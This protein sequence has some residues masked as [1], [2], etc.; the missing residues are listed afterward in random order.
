MTKLALLPLILLAACGDNLKPGGAADVDSGVDAAPLPPRAIVV[1]GDFV[2]GH[3]GVMSVVDMTTRTIMTNVAP[4]GAVGEDPVLRHYGNELYV[5]NR[6]SGNNVTILDAATFAFV[7]QLGTG[8]SSNP[9]DAV[10]IGD[11]VFVA[12]LGNKGGVMVERGSTVVTEIDLSADDPDGKPNCN[13]V[14]FA[15]NKL[16]FSCGLLDDTNMFLPP[17]GPGKIYV[18]NPTTLAVEQTVTMMTNNPIALFEQI[19]PS[20]PH[21]ND[22]LMPTIDFGT[23]MGC[24]ERITSAGTFGSAGCVVENSALGGFAFASRIGF[25]GTH[26]RFGVS[27]YPNGTV[28]DF[29]L[30]ANTLGA[31]SMT[32]TAQVVAD[33]AICPGGE[34][35]IAD[36]PP[37][38]STAA[39]GLRIYDGTTEKTT[40]PLAVG[41][42]PSSSHG[43]VC[44]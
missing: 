36:N 22:V 20:A 29:D 15:F 8:A 42:K 31:T 10:A 6:A 19:P 17:R 27:D 32:A 28:R 38:P 11:K 23:G 7:D 4:A 34:M 14:Y 16:L 43:L 1:A 18:V 44:F 35:V 41:L 40:E 24:V 13:S 12:T 33:L 2:P 30:A 3:P 25:E 39:N 26:A 9:Q 5:V 37:P 21:G